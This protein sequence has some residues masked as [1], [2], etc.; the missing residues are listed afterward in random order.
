MISKNDFITRSRNVLIKLN[1]LLPILVIHKNREKS[2]WLT[3]L[4]TLH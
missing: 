4:G 3:A 2:I 1:N